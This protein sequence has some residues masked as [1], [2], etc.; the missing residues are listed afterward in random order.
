MNTETLAKAGE[1]LL[2]PEWRRPLARVLGPHHPDGAREQIDPRLVMRWSTG[3]RPV[4]AWVAP[5]LA[6]LLAERAGNLQQ[7]AQEA[8][9]LARA[10]RAA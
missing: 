10:L 8:E 1:L 6:G 2:G 7:Q 4:P 3:E 9:D 5:A